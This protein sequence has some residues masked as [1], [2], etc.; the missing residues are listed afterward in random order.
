MRRYAAVHAANVD[1][2]APAAG[3]DRFAVGLLA[4]A[5]RLGAGVLPGAQELDVQRMHAHLDL[6]RNSPPIIAGHQSQPNAP[7]VSS[8]VDQAV[9]A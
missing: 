3:V 2:H 4:D 7:P 6:D 5:E 1:Q 8:A 9:E